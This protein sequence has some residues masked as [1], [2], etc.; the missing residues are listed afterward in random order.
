MTAG[1]PQQEIG[2]FPQAQGGQGEDGDEVESQG[3]A[4]LV[5]GDAMVDMQVSTAKRYP[6]SVT[7]FR[8]QVLNL[9][10]LDEETAG[11]CLY[12]L[13]R[14]GKAIE[15]PS[16]RF[17][18][19]ALYAWGNA[20][21]EGKVIGQQGNFIL[22]EGTFYDLERNVA[23]RKTV[24][25][26][27]TNKEGRLYD[28]DMIGVTGNAAISIALR[29]AILAGIPKALWKQ[30]YLQTRAASVGQAGNLSK[31]RQSIVDGFGKMGVKPEQVFALLE[32]QG[33]E[34][35]TT[36]HC[37]TARGLYTSI[38]DGE[39]Q[40]EDVFS[41]RAPGGVSTPS[42]DER[43]KNQQKKD[44]TAASGTAPPAEQK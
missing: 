31:V 10:C 20:R 23:I 35:M 4:V 7:K 14:G 2:T 16:A 5:P 9:A 1:K 37:I 40:L 42:L 18:E 3:V 21:A 19:I 36:D 44:A 33:I 38:K 22:A 30:M 26:R 41:P 43:L 27:I 39:Q 11:A 32:M 13:K 12:A 17:A 15:G 29:N 25:R 24:Q 28:D 6:R 8:K 34:D